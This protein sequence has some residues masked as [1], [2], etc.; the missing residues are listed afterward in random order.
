MDEPLILASAS[1]IRKK[2]LAAAGLE[3]R[4]ESALVDEEA[5]K[6]IFQVDRQAAADCALALAEAKARQIAENHRHALV[7]GADQILVCDKIWLNKPA[8]LADARAQ[9]QALRG[10]THKLVTAVCVVREVVR[11]WHT[12]SSAKLT[13]RYFSDAFLDTYLGAEQPAALGSVGAYRFEE[14]GIQLFSDIQGD[15]FTILGLPL[16]ELLGFLRTCGALAS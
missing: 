3:V 9:L 16:L 8:D 14:R 1:P 7:V 11:I 4:V 10:R 13:M 12:V 5:I 6:R 2:L 15:Y